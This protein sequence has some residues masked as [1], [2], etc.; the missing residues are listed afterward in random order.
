MLL[1]MFGNAQS[2]TIFRT[3]GALSHKESTDS[4][5]MSV[6]IHVR[7]DQQSLQKG[8]WYQLRQSLKE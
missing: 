6:R 1:K 7:P 4:K 8:S 3:Q 2:S 5:L